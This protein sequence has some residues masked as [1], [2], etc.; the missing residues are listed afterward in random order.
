MKLA[1]KPL[2]CTAGYGHECH[3]STSVHTEAAVIAHCS[4]RTGAQDKFEAS[5]L[6]LE[7]HFKQLQMCYLLILLDEIRVNLRAKKSSPRL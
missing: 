2:L 4:Q 3:M 7:V 6:V 1:G 5:L